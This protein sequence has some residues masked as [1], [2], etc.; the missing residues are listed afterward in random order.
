MPEP[1][2]VAIQN[3]RKRIAVSKEL[4]DSNAVEVVVNRLAGERFAIDAQ[5]KNGKPKK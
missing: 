5:P 2:D 4:I 1:D 3:L